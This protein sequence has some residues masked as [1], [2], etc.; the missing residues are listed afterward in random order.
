[1]LFT[2]VRRSHCSQ[3]V[4]LRAGWRGSVFKRVC[5]GVYRQLH[6]LW[7][8]GS[9]G[10]ESNSSGSHRA[11]HVSSGQVFHHHSQSTAPCV[12][13][14]LPL[15][16]LCFIKFGKKYTK[17][18]V[19]IQE[20]NSPSPAPTELMHSLTLWVWNYAKGQRSP[21]HIPAAST[22]SEPNTSLISWGSDYQQSWL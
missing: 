7:S 3:V 16:Q 21:D 1:M 12:G 6:D 20:C 9:V 22:F 5:H 8:Q 17:Q 14:P 2:Q 4:W 10:S 19:G 18:I 13:A 15:L 11:G